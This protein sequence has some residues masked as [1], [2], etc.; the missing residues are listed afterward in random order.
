MAAAPDLRGAVTST[1]FV[2]RMRALK[3]WSG[4]TYRQLAAR[5]EES[6][7]ILPS[8]TLASTLGR[9]SL[10]RRDV[11]AAFVRAC[12]GDAASVRTWLRVHAE[13]AS[14]A[15]GP[16]SPDLYDPDDPDGPD[17]HGAAGQ[18]AAAG[19]G[20]AGAG[21]PAGAGPAGAPEAPGGPAVSTAPAGPGPTAHDDAA[22]RG[23]AT[24]SGGA[25]VSGA[26]AAS[27]EPRRGEHRVADDGAP[28]GASDLLVGDGGRARGGQTP[29]RMP[30]WLPAP[31]RTGG[32]LAAAVL[33]L[34]VLA[35]AVTYAVLA[36]TGDALTR[37]AA[38]GGGPKPG[39]YRIRS[40][41]TSYCLAEV[42]G[43][44]SGDVHQLDCAGSIPVY[45]VQPAESGTYWIHSLHPAMGLGCLGVA[46][47]AMKDAAPMGDDY[48]GHRG[49]A[50][51]F[52]MQKVAAPVEGYRI[53]LLHTGACVTVPGATER[54]GVQVLQMPCTGGD[55][56]QVFRFDPVPAPTHVPPPPGG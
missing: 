14:G 11:V 10:P 23:A 26:A 16:S 28:F 12:G 47:G 53:R 17:R 22:A 36:F 37:D 25:A 31:L 54:K 40:A 30:P 56:G 42:D 1:A 45:E 7:D 32:R 51:K 8:S 6:G 55:A 49:D 29:R 5:A 41:A 21:A 38:S 15:V 9:R 18:E 50:E 33:G 20:A 43:E 44:E 34:V 52:R 46:G 2:L 4:L 39:T 3:D 48:C 24:A 13:I 19:A 35:A 27:P